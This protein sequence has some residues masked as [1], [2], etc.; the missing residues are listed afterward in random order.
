MAKLCTRMPLEMRKRL[1]I[2]MRK[3]WA[4]KKLEQRTYASYAVEPRTLE[5]MLAL[6]QVRVQV[7]KELITLGL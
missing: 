6:A 7:L 2:S 4:K 3:A 5:D 1:S